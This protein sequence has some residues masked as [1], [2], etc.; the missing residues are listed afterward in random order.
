[1][2]GLNRIYGSKPAVSKG[3]WSIRAGSDLIFCN[4]S[5]ECPGFGH[6]ICEMI[7]H[8]FRFGLNGR[9]GLGYRLRRNF[10]P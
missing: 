3:K 5:E 2:T 1:M 6:S 9:Y 10:P 7:F 4:A 8:L